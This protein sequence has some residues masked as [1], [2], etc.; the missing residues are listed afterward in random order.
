[1]T[2]KEALIAANTVLWILDNNFVTENKK[3]IEFTQHRFLIDYMSDQHP[4]KVAIKSSQVGLTV[5]ETLDAIHLAA[6][7]NMTSIHTLQTNDVI[8]GFVQPKVDPII[9]MNPAI[10]DVL[11]VDSQNLKQFGDA[12]VFY[13]GAQAESQAINISA[14]VLK[15]DELDRSKPKVVEMYQ[16]RLDHSEYKWMRRFSNP[17]AIGYGVDALW[18]DSNQL[19]WFVKCS[20]CGHKWYVDFEQN[21]IEKN[22]YVDKVREVFACGKCNK[23]ITTRDRIRGEWIAKYP[24]RTHRHGY[25]FSQMMAPWFSA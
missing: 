17:S 4:D 11:K 14:D 12:F 1:M 15:I 6:F 3:P 20:H 19:H 8:K 18:Q 24:N 21:E 7:R 25:W 23:E 16:S 9:Q 10:S 5:A 22:H 13:R 2:E